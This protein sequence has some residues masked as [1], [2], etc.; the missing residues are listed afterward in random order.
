M[1]AQCI[2]CGSAYVQTPDMSNSASLQMEFGSAPSPCRVA[3]PASLVVDRG[4]SS[5][6]GPGSMGAS[7]SVRERSASLARGISLCRLHELDS[8]SVWIQG[9]EHLER[10][11]TEL[12]GEMLPHAVH[13]ALRC[14]STSLH[15]VTTCR[16]QFTSIHHPRPI[17]PASALADHRGCRRA[18]APAAGAERL[19][20]V[21]AALVTAFDPAV[22]PVFEIPCFSIFYRKFTEK[23]NAMGAVWMPSAHHRLM[24]TALTG[25]SIMPM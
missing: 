15:P 23:S 11:A 4:R 8:A 19:P 14:E 13:A 22:M 2:V 24:P 17:K 9:A 10:P 7:A 12:A 1:G 3:G 21:G 5:A 20:P 6:I 16:T 25:P 18:A